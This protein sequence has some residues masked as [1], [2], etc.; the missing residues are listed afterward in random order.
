M[1]ARITT[2]PQTGRVIV[3]DGGGDPAAI[4]DVTRQVADA[5]AQGE[6]AIV[7]LSSA[8]RIDSRLLR[9]LV[10]ADKHARASGRQV[11]LRGVQGDVA[12]VLAATGM[13]L[14]FQI[15]RPSGE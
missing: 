15:A 2:K 10:A 13:D 9:A 8:T 1:A 3:L 5:V 4:E 7:D 11:V 12:R 14:Q 6:N